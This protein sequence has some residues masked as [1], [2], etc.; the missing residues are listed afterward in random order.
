M[1]NNIN[2][3][4]NLNIFICIFV[5]RACE[6]HWKIG[7]RIWGVFSI[8]CYLYADICSFEFDT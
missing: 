4:V 7:F 3:G 6:N 1:T 5:L 2:H 8:V